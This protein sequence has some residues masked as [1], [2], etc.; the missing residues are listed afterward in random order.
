MEASVLFDSWNRSS[1]T[2]QGVE[3]R[4]WGELFPSQSSYREKNNTKK[5]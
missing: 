2:V 4:G 3:Q 1:S 5:Y